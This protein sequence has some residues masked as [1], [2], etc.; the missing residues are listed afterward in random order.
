MLGFPAKAPDAAEAVGLQDR[1]F[2]CRAAKCRGLPVP[3]CEQ[4]A[5]R[6]RLHE[7][8][9]ERVR[10]DPERADVV[11]EVDALDDAGMRRATLDQR[12]AE[13]LEEDLAVH[14]ARAVLG[15]LAGAAGY[16]VLVTFAATLGVVGRPET[17]HHGLDFLEDEAVVVERTQRNDIVLIDRIEWRSLRRKS[18][19]AVIEAGRRLGNA[20]RACLEGA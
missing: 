16:H 5:V 13:R 2:E 4:R 15:D 9:A 14:A 19:R 12:A 20:R 18:V 3:D 11:L 6:D 7:A 8:R 17:V 1:H 10:G